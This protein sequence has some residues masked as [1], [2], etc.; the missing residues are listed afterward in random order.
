LTLPGLYEREIEQLQL[1]LEQIKQ[2]FESLRCEK[3]EQREHKEPERENCADADGLKRRYRFVL[4]RQDRVDSDGLKR[5]HRYVLV[6][7]PKREDPVEVDG[8]KHRHRYVLALAL[9][10]LERRLNIDLFGAEQ[11]S[12]IPGLI[13]KFPES[14]A[15]DSEVARKWREF[16]AQHGSKAFKNIPSLR[17]GAC[18]VKR[19][20][21]RFTRQYSAQ[22]FAGFTLADLNH[23]VDALYAAGEF[24]SKAH[25]VQV[26]RLMTLVSSYPE[27]LARPLDIDASKS[28]S[29]FGPNDA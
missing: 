3:K 11:Y 15:D 22:D 13:A 4:Q 12:T 24:P 5:R 19:M 14:E 27:T 25:F 28:K 6:P 18:V 21:L 23:A 9:Q 17:V 1:Q 16:W 10:S 8:L 7:E 26:R 29:T 2:E 20:D